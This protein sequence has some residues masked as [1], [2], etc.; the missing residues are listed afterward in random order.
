MLAMWLSALL[1]VL[2]AGDATAAAMQGATSSSSS[3]DERERE[4]SER[5]AEPKMSKKRKR[6]MRPRRAKRYRD[7][8]EDDDAEDDDERARLE[9]AAPDRT[10][11]RVARYVSSEVLRTVANK[12]DPASTLNARA[13]CGRAVTCVVKIAHRVHAAAAAA[14][15]VAATRSTTPAVATASPMRVAPWRVDARATTKSRRENERPVTATEDRMEE[16]EEEEE[17]E[18]DDDDDF[19]AAE[20]FFYHL[21]RDMTLSDRHRLGR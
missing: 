8:R 19:I 6:E 11:T 4:K 15:T 12:T 16:E 9:T 3:S 18:E 20:A 1:F 5:D 17:E 2:D 10:A 21:S 13:H 14:A 7:R